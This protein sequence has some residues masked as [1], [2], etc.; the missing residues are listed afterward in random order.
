MK[1]IDLNCDLGEGF[2]SYRIGRDDEV[3][4]HIT[5][6]NVACGW[7]AGDPMVMDY[8]VQLAKK[9]GGKRGGPIPAIPIF[10]DSAGGICLAR[11]V[12]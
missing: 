3:M 8:T 9:E 7:H 12:S 6:A 10:W 5:S 4:P 2:A 1:V 11:P